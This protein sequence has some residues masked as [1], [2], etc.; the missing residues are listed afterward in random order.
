MTVPDNSCLV[1]VEE[2]EEVA[3]VDFVARRKARRSENDD[4]VWVLVLHPRLGLT[5]GS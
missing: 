1:R 2:L 3:V 4:F 5:L